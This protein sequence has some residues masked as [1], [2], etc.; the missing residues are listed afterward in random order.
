MSLILAIQNNWTFFGP[1][2]LADKDRLAED[3][4]TAIHM[5]WPAVTEASFFR[6]VRVKTAKR[7]EFL[8]PGIT[9]Y[10]FQKFKATIWGKIPAQNVCAEV[11]V[12]LV[13]EIL[14][15]AQPLPKP[16]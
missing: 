7:E 1:T 10:P 12:V 9:D 5:E 2:T 3:I 6:V 13:G 4:L 8:P 11:Q 15:I 16:D 14:Y